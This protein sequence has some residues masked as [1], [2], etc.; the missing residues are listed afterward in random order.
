MQVLVSFTSREDVV[1]SI[2]KIITN[3]CLVLD[4]SGSMNREDKYPLLR[5]AI[6]HLIAALSDEDYLTI[7]LFSHSHDTILFG[8][9][10]R[11]RDRVDKLLLSID[12]SGVMFGHHTLLAPGLK[13][14]VQ[15]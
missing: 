14:V 15:K 2:P 8:Q 4:V 7:I 9:V 13:V 10:G 11:I 3:L 1:L 6:P 5:Q 12:Q